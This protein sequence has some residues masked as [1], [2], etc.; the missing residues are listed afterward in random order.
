MEQRDAKPAAQPEVLADDDLRARS[1]ELLDFPAIREELASRTRLVSARRLAL[2]LTP[3][4]SAHEVERLQGETAE[5]LAFLEKTGDVNLHMGE[6]PSPAVARAALGGAVSGTDL[7]SVAAWV[8]VQRRARLALDGARDVAPRLAELAQDIPDLQEISQR[9]GAAIGT[10][11]EVVDGATPS[12]GAL[13]RQVREA[14][15]RVT[16]ALERTIQSEAGQESLQDQVIS[17]RGERLVLQ[18]KTELR[19]RVPGIV[20]GASN[21]GATLFVEPLATVELCNTWK[22][23]ALEEERE[24]ARVLRELSALVG[25]AAGDIRRG[26][27]ITAQLDFILARARYSTS[28][29]CVA[30]IA[31]ANSAVRQ[32]EDS[33][34]RVRLLGA[35]HPLLGRESIPI[36]VHIGPEWSVLVITGPNTG[37]K[38]VAMKTVGLLATMNQS[39]LQIPAEQGS[40][41][42]VFDGIYADVGDQQSIRQSVS[43]FGSH[44]RSVVEIL[45]H[46]T[47]SSLTLF[48]ELGTSTDPEEGS[49]LAKAI[50]SYLAATGMITVATTHHRAVA[51]HAEATPGM[52]N[53]SVD[54]DPTTLEPS[55]H[56]TVGVPGR[57]YAMS[58][59]ARLG[60]PAEIMEQ[61]R[62]LLEPQ[63]ILFE[64][65]LN[66]LQ[67]ERSQLRER[68]QQ[69]DEARAGAEAEREKAEAQRADLESRR[70]EIVSG[71]RAELVG[72]YEELRKK[73]RRAESA[74]SW[75]PSPGTV[76]AQDILE[77]VSELDGARAGLDALDKRASAMSGEA[78]RK[79][80]AVGDAVDVLGLGVHGTVASIGGPGEDVEIAV[81][82]VRLKVDASRLA[83][84]G[85]HDVEHEPDGPGVGYRLGPV[86]GTMELDLRG[87]RADEALVSVEE[88]LDRAL[89]DGLASV[90]IIHG[91]GTG[92]LRRAVRELLERHPLAK[93]FAPEAPDKGGDGATAVELT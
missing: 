76:Q 1:L 87:Y 84:S 32:R 31:P 67:D 2:E 63:H 86:L 22:E 53:A 12:L 45:H 73:L 89:R 80:L 93:S 79:A 62:S 75:S 81:G 19:H 24:V 3:S 91:K 61:A 7:Q 55:Y 65:W 44:M 39:G 35:R 46:A 66:E 26:A 17:V 28:L 5:G 72:E 20:L 82:G 83:P 92:A 77:A 58:V 4:Y 38:T 71:M 37:G 18:V 49:A 36:N 15:E 69:A 41:L 60:L 88:F 90:R 23:L 48:D 54:L 64:D 16:E 68:L 50:L 43:T 40:S 13:R 59:A 8:D 85:T 27:E 57:S 34:P 30:A 14:Y 47:A 56:L 70:D 29:S 9:I 33:G 74:L 52:M 6:D 25:D 51:T 78:E 21:T 11:G 42:P 10:R